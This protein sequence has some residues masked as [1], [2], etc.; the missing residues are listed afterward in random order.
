MTG[1]TS[2]GCLR[3]GFKPLRGKKEEFREEEQATAASR[4]RRRRLS[5]EG[6][7]AALQGWPGRLLF[8]SKLLFLP[9][10]GGTL[11]YA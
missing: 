11:P 6:M 10:E 2:A 8:F 4:Q 1:A 7:P 9:A 5:L 3:G